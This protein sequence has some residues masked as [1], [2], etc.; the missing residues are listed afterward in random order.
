M[1]QNEGGGKLVIDDNECKVQTAMRSTANRPCDDDDDTQSYLLVS[2]Y[3][4]KL[5]ISYAQISSI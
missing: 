1:V 3:G 2:I 5:I 4:D